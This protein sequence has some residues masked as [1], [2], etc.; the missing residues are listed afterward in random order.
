MGS[1]T[2]V[3][4]VNTAVCEETFPAVHDIIGELHPG[5][6]KDFMADPVSSQIAKTNDHKE[7]VVAEEEVKEKT[8]ENERKGA[9]QR[10]KS[11]I[12]I[13]GVAVAVIGA[14]FGVTKKLREK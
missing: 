12:I 5:I 3:L 7:L 2:G 1:P 13:S 11:A 9:A 4:D 6:A 14:I 8:K 10:I